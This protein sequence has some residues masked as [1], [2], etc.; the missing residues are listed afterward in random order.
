MDSYI[1][2]GQFKKSVFFNHVVT[3]TT[4]FNEKTKPKFFRL[5]KM[6]LREVTCLFQGPFRKMKQRPRWGN[7]AGDMTAR[8]DFDSWRYTEFGTNCKKWNV[9]RTGPRINV[10]E[11]EPCI[12]EP[13]ATK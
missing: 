3:L 6:G 4:D 2:L 12:G 1:N 7:I 5:G 9:V 8:C 10:A 13:I 11:T